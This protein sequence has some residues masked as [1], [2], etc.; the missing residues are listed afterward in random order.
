VPLTRSNI[1][2]GLL[3]LCCA[4]AASLSPL[5]GGAEAAGKKAIW[6]PTMLPAGNVNCPPPRID[7]CSAFP[8]YQALGVDTFQIQLQWDQ[9][10]PTRPANP[11]NPNDPA[12]RWPPSV[13]RA[14]VDGAATGIE[15]ALMVK[16]SPPWAN[17]GRSP[18]WAPQRSAYSAFLRA[19][20]AR[21]PGVRKW[22]IWGEPTRKE[23]FQPMAKKSKKGPRR[24]ARLLDAAYKTLKSIDRGNV[25]IGGMSVNAGTV[26]PNR[27]LRNMARGGKMPKMDLWGHNPFDNRRPRL[28]DRPIRNFRGFNDIDTLWKEIKKAYRRQKK[29]GR[30]RGLFLSEITY[31]TDRRATVFEGGFFVS[32]R[33]QARRISAAYKIAN[34]QKYVKTLGY[35]T[36]MD[37]LSGN[38]LWGL[39]ESDGDRKPGFF[40]Y[41]AA[42]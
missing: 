20:A 4:G 17:G 25:V 34:R 1:R 11:T 2:R 23:A 26:T 32:R 38:N 29:K 31:P 16:L 14:V 10:A 27:Y 35:F 24:Y 41:A 15:V 21:Y 13:D 12:Y 5:A 18:I 28:K 19:A 39:I 3:A 8:T 42:P 6:G 22:M 36:L 7:P 9:V 37:E 33:E 30:P 40:A